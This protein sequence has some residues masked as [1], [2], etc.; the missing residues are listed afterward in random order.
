MRKLLCIC[1]SA[2][3]TVSIPTA[4]ADSLRSEKVNRLIEQVRLDA[5]RQQESLTLI[6]E[7]DSE[8]SLAPWFSAHGVTS[9]YRHKQL[10][11][12]SIPAGALAPLLQALP[13]TVLVRFPYPH[14]A[15]SIMGQGVVL[16][17]AADM[18]V[19]GRDGSGVSIGVIDLGFTNLANSQA[20]GDLPSNLSVTDY[21]GT[22]TGGADHGTNVA[23]IV[24][25][26]A[27]GAF[28]YLAKINTETQLAQA[29][30]DMKLAGVKVIVHSVAWF[31]AAFYDGTGP[32]CSITDGA[33]TAGILW[34]NAMGNHRYRH[35]LA[36]FTDANGDLRHE[37]SPGQN[38][39]TINLSA[40]SP[41]SL[42]LNWDA[43]PQTT[44]DY[45][46]Y[47]YNGNPDAGGVLVASSTNQQSGKGPSW[48]PY[49]YEDIQYTPS[50][51]GTYYIVVRKLVSSTPNLRLT[52]FSLGPELG[53]NTV[54]S[55]LVEP[56]DCMSVIGVGATDLN[57]SPEVFSSEGP[58]TDGRNKPAVT[59]PDRVQTSMYTNFAGTSAATP[60]VG[61]ALALLV[62]QNPS[63]TTSQ[64]RSTLTGLAKD[65][66]TLGFD[67][68]TGY[69]RVSLDADAD[70]WN[71]DRDNCPLIYNPD[72]LDSNSN[73][74][75]NVC[76]PPV[77]SSFT[78]NKGPVG[79]FVTILGSYL[80]GATRVSFNGVP[81]TVWYG[82]GPTTVYAFVPNGAT[83][84]P[85][86]IQTANGA[87]NSS[88]QIFTI[89]APPAITSFSPGSGSIGSFV[90]ISGSNF[91]GAANLYFNG[92][93]TTMWTAASSTTIYAFVPNGATTGPIKVVTPNGSG[94]SS[95]NFIVR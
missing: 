44:V 20:S 15:T 25:E 17:G 31:G 43:Y 32:L 37:F 62:Q 88:P 22:G 50:M 78:P 64:I 57:D 34:V 28:L 47:L 33:E 9:R 27:P 6:L 95:I 89:N 8:A 84:G 3:I 92:V 1:F 14:R 29:V 73:G 2:V 46:L 51:G 61:G 42:I 72:Q 71:H 65:V 66:H 60:H 30:N 83:S 55:S 54:A 86:N 10:H 75:G 70:G 18:Q 13:D 41:V 67:Y 49:P 21:T 81:A 16:S 59:G 80:N 24:H 85:I 38:Y 68:R 39:N 53:I 90:T 7:T 40:G 52:L 12:I 93:A 26:M 4:Q 58:T 5:K 36:T 45:D 48:Y 69:G 19:L 74:V 76:E 56:A 79:S 63:M 94:M 77:I 91:N 87:T 35:Y 11:E 23:E 82:Y